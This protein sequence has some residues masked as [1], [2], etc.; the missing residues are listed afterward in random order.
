MH[1]PATGLSRF[2]MSEAMPSSKGRGQECPRHT[3]AFGMTIVYWVM[4]QV[5]VKSL[6]PNHR[7]VI[8]LHSPSGVIETGLHLCPPV[9]KARKLALEIR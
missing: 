3:G 9:K 5:S 1:Q 8:A 4:S 7:L 6:S 2:G